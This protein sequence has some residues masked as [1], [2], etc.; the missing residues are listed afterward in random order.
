MWITCWKCGQEVWVE[1]QRECRHCYEV[2]RR[3][4]DCENYVAEDSSCTILG[5]PVGRT[6]AAQPNRLA[7]AYSCQFYTPSADALSHRTPTA[8]TPAPPPP[9]AA[10]VAPAA[11]PRGPSHLEDVETITIPRE[12]PLKAPRRP[13]IIAHRG[14]SS[15][16]PENTQTALQM[17]VAAGAQAVEFDVQITRD[18]QAVVL[19][20]ASVD[21]TTDGQGPVAEMDLADVRR[22]DAG[23]WFGPEFAKAGVPTLAEAIAALP[24]PTLLIIHLRAHENA[25]D[26]CE[27][28]VAEAIANAQARKRTVVTHHTRHGLH[29]LRELD[30]HLRLCWIPAG[31]EPGLEYVDDAYYMGYRIVQPTLR[32]VDE[33]FVA[34]AHEKGMWINVF[35]AD[36][37]A[38]MERL[39]TLGVQG[40]L[41]NFPERMRAL[42]RHVV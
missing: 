25:T 20:D 28:A 10:P 37:V 30:P 9:T 38:D 40:I 16:A 34:Y 6:E 18:N 23:N 2:T 11:A 42:L 27:R 7:L 14:A 35:W 24:P 19:H 22:L 15:A 33:L 1:T 29:R 5:V 4:L 12:P 31:G 39:I 36:E 3:C 32:E 41:T 21:R 26:R 17:A 8:A 13:L